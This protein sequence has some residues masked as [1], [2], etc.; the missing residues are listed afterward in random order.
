MAKKNNN[1]QQFPSWPAIW[2]SWGQSF[3][4]FIFS[5]FLGN[6]T[7]GR[8]WTT[9]STLSTL[10]PP[11]SNHRR[12]QTSVA[13][14]SRRMTQPPNKDCRSSRHWGVSWGRRRCTIGLESIATATVRI[15]EGR[16]DGFLLM[17]SC[18][19]YWWWVSFWVG[20]GLW[21]LLVMGF[22]LNFNSQE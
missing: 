13:P 19:C 14:I 15:G 10:P 11:Q 17:M 6:Q 3:F 21:L 8:A 1:K 4:F 12:D 22:F 2:V 7:M 20:D 9:C 16:S 5:R 18:S